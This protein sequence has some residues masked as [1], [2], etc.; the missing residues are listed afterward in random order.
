MGLYTYR[1]SFRRYPKEFPGSGAKL[2][3]NDVIQSLLQKPDMVFLLYWWFIFRRQRDEDPRP[4]P[5]SR[6]LY[7]VPRD[8]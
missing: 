7:L 6:T 5:I 8:D 3:K 2:S 4:A 1:S